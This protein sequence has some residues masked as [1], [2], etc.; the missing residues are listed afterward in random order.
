MGIDSQRINITG[1]NALYQLAN[2]V[3]L[4]AVNG[5]MQPCRCPVYQG[6]YCIKVEWM[7]RTMASI[8]SSFSPMGSSQ[9]LLLARVGRLM[10]T[11]V[12]ACDSPI[13]VT[14]ADRTG[15]YCRPA[16]KDALAFLR[17]LVYGDNISF[18]R[19]INKPDKDMSGMRA[20]ALKQ[21]AV[22]HKVTLMQALLDCAGLTPYRYRPII[23]FIEVFKKIKAK[24]GVISTSQAL[25]EILDKTGYE[26]W[27]QFDLNADSFN[28]ISELKLAVE[29]QEEAAGGRLDIAGY[30]TRVELYAG[31][32]A[33]QHPD[34]VQLM[35]IHSS[36]GM[37]FPFVTVCGMNE[38]VLPSH[39]GD[40][41]EER[42]LA[43]VACSRAR[44]GLML[45]CVGESDEPGSI[46][47]SRFLSDMEPYMTVQ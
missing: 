23:D 17:L 26:E 22:K 28:D 9:H 40:I 2:T 42:R 41:D 14:V 11:Q 21:Y 33:G 16:I 32:A 4:F 44:N 20:Y 46:L 27:V 30:L 1:D 6:F 25:A 35:T 36:K 8:F 39:E 19:I 47:P 45:T 7:K 3:V 13:C 38:G 29:E 10:C 31:F 43:Y 34:S 12:A 18:E 5:L 37:E 24:L 15:F